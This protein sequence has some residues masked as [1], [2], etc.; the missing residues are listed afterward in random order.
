MKDYTMKMTEDQREYYL[1]EVRNRTYAL[2]A[3]QLL[4]ETGTDRELLHYERQLGY[5]DGQMLALRRLF[6]GDCAAIDKS[7]A[8]HDAKLE[9]E[10]IARLLYETEAND[11]EA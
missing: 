11:E 1:D 2:K 4:S 9:G 5:H 7:D 8:T 3:L 10:R 6:P